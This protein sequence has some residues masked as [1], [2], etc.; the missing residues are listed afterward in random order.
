MYNNEKEYCNLW[1]VLSTEQNAVFSPALT[2]DRIFLNV[3]QHGDGPETTE[4]RKRVFLLMAMILCRLGIGISER[5]TVHEITEGVMDPILFD[6]SNRYT[7][8]QRQ[9]VFQ[10]LRVVIH[11]L[12]FIGACR[13]A[14]AVSNIVYIL[15]QHLKQNNKQG[16]EAEHNL[17]RVELSDLIR[18]SFDLENNCYENQGMFADHPESPMPVYKRQVNRPPQICKHG[19]FM[20]VGTDYQYKCIMQTR[21]ET[22]D[23]SCVH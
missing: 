16:I 15:F 13:I 23:K 1:K 8:S 9:R 19:V 18:S 20:V 14:C 6:I 10:L 5:L 17:L 2:R 11:N 4:T 22:Q 7:V 12:F 21:V 3:V